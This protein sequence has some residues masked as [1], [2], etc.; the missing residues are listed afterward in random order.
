MNIELRTKNSKKYQRIIDIE[1]CSSCGRDH[2][3]MTFSL[4]ENPEIIEEEVFLFIG[5]CMITGEN[6]Y[7][8]YI[9]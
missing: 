6:V 7:M 1:N 2:T 5:Q 4:L 9:D 3:R 8:R